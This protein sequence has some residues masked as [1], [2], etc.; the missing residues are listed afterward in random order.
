MTLRKMLTLGFGL[1]ISIIFISSSVSSMRFNQSE[2]DFNTYR[3]LSSLN[4]MFGIVNQ[5]IYNARL[6][7]NK[8]I[9]TY[10]KEDKEAA[11]KSIKEVFK[12]IDLA[13]D[14]AI[15]FD[16]KDDVYVLE[17][18]KQQINNYRNSLFDIEEL[19]DKRNEILNQ[20]INPLGEDGVKL[21]MSI[22]KKLSDD[23]GFNYTVDASMMQQHFILVRYNILSFLITNNI[24]DIKESKEEIKIVEE[25]AHK[26]IGS[27]NNS[28]VLSDLNS[29]NLLLDNINNSLDVVSTVIHQRN[30]IISN[31]L[32]KEG[33]SSTLAI[34]NMQSSIKTE[35]DELGPVL[36]KRFSDSTIL[37]LLILLTSIIASLCIAIV[38]YQ[39][40]TRVIG[41][42]PNYIQKIVENISTGDLS[43]DIQE[44]GKETGIYANILNMRSELRRIIDSFHQISDSVSKASNE[45][46]V[47]MINTEKNAQKELSQMEQIATAINELSS[48]A[49]EVSL[50]AANA[51]NAASS[52][53]S[54]VEEGR[55]SLSLSDEISNKVDTSI[56]ETSKIV[57]QLQEY[58]VEIGTVVEVINSISE[59]TNLLALNAA[60]EA[61]R[62]GEQGRGFAVVADEVRSLAAKTQQS[63]IDI[64]EIISRLQSQAKEA[65]QFMNSNLALA[66]D[67]RDC[68]DQLKS[69]FKSITTSV[70]LISDMN[71]Q[72]ATASEEQSGVTQDISQ[73]ISQTFDIVNHNLLG[74][75]ETKKSSEELSILATKQKD[76]LSFFKV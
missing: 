7:S 29:L 46:S 12:S 43:I 26:L 73:N 53:A 23:D 51:E 22:M 1:I 17:T 54:N 30:D 16:Y 38:I 21:I 34:E 5:N 52:A 11:E 25:I 70:A 49:N 24:D 69:A 68:S 28:D 72:V 64:Q 61:A 62:A 32:D 47:V 40:I 57:N 55:Y 10:N 13:L 42:E 4:I 65:N 56:E 2:I 67:S 48:T 37:I 66:K 19:M 71:T 39:R 63:T 20:K 75:Q 36:V 60:I 27:I 8:Y 15:E 45:L 9:R 44:S 33:I 59:Q 50:N 14:L 6:S 58:S 18:I 76:L 74:I 3:S 35:Q 31:V 41:G